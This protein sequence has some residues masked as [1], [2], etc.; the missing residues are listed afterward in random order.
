MLSKCVKN[1]PRVVSRLP[2]ILLA[3]VMV[4]SHSTVAWTGM[5]RTGTSMHAFQFRMQLTPTTCWASND[6]EIIEND[7][8]LEQQSTLLIDSD[9]QQ[10]QFISLADDDLD[11]PLEGED[12]CDQESLP[13]GLTDGFYVIK[14]YTTPSDNFDLSAPVL[15]EVNCDRLDITRKNVTLPLALMLMDPQEY[16]SLSRARKAC[17]YVTARRAS[18][19]F[20]SILMFCKSLFLMRRHEY[21]VSHPF[22]RIAPS[23][24]QRADTDS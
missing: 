6:G 2:T 13:M 21:T 9:L 15:A 14:T 3:M 4:M 24:Q 12:D 1:F 17:R 8:L 10:E 23:F 16:P 22:R 7:G 11:A 18:A 19:S 5:H 20:L